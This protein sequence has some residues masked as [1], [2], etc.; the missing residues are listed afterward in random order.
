MNRF[1]WVKHLL[2]FCIL[3]I[4]SAVIID[5]VS[6]FA[7]CL[8]AQAILGFV[9]PLPEGAWVRQVAHLEFN[10]QVVLK[11]AQLFS[12]NLV[13]VTMLKEQ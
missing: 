10:F 9:L 5:S 13:N 3:A 12:G 6:L 7:L 11:P 1:L 2:F 8:L 4:N